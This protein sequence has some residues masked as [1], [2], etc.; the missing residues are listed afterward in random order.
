MAV[1]RRTRAHVTVFCAGLDL[2]LWCGARVGLEVCSVLTSRGV[3][4]G[5]DSIVAIYGEGAFTVGDF[6]GRVRV[7]VA[8][9]LDGCSSEACRDVAMIL[10]ALGGTYLSRWHEQY[11]LW[12]GE[13]RGL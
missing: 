9:T 12:S 2:G 5:R 7:D 6:P 13:S 1:T 11:D 10:L 3:R 8:G 4:K